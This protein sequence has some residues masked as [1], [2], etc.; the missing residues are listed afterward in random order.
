MNTTWT[1]HCPDIECDG[2]AHSIKNALGKLAGVEAVEVDLDSKT[3][4]V[5]YDM[6]QTSNAVLRERLT[7]MG[8]PPQE[9]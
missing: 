6:A 8:F 9:G 1:A 5:T 7:Q 3:V 4:T 2:C